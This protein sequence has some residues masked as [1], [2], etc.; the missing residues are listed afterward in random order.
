MKMDK[1]L[2]QAQKMQAQMT[3]AQEELE[4]TVIEGTAGGGAVKVSVNGHGEMLSI[5]ISKEAVDP[6]D[7]E[8]LEDMIISAAKDAS[9]KAKELSNT[10]MNSL[11]GGMGGFPGLM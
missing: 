7:V 6:N 2:K 5:K 10:K 8:M 4:K 3:L 1:L 9:D 11:T